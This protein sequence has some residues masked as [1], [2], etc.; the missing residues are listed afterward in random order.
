MGYRWPGS[1]FALVGYPLL[2]ERSFAGAPDL[3]TFLRP[4]GA[5]GGIGRLVEPSWPFRCRLTECRIALVA[6]CDRHRDDLD[7]PGPDLFAVEYFHRRG[8]FDLGVVAA[9]SAVYDW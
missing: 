4:A 6:G 7:G 8:D 2:P 9:L 5:G 1:A 3:Y